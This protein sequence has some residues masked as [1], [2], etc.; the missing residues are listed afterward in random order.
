MTPVAGRVWTKR[1]WSVPPDHGHRSQQLAVDPFDSNHDTAT[2]GRAHSS[3]V[4]FSPQIDGSAAKPQQAMVMMVPAG[5]DSLAAY[6]VAR[7]RKDGGH[8]ATLSQALVEKQL[9]SVVCLCAQGGGL[10]GC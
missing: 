1:S 4:T 7:A 3:Q 10:P 9:G 6:A 8:A 2:P 5:Q